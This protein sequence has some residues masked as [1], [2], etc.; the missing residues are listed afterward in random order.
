[1][2]WLGFWFCGCQDPVMNERGL[3][4]DRSRGLNQMEG[5]GDPTLQSHPHK[6]RWGTPV[7]D[8]DNLFD[9]ELREN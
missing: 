4:D 3:R 8:R 2:M 5:L 7:R 6:P 1:M 9:L